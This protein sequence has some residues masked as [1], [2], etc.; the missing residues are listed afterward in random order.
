MLPGRAYDLLIGVRDG[1]AMY[2][3]Y[4]DDV[5]IRRRGIQTL[6][7]PVMLDRYTD[8]V[9]LQPARRRPV[10]IRFMGSGTQ[11]EQTTFRQERMVTITRVS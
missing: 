5:G 10:N 6:P 7:D 9:F 2:G 1:P 11:P 3:G 4:G 8:A